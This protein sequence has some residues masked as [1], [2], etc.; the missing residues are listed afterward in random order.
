MISGGTSPT[1][2]HQLPMGTRDVEKMKKAVLEL[3]DTERA[4]VKVSPSMM[5]RTMLWVVMRDL[6]N[7]R[8]IMTLLFQITK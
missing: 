4:Y 2:S 8:E 5:M 1:H 3:V 7:N 6:R